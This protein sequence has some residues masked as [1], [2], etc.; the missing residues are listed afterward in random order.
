MPR[1]T[2][3]KTTL[4]GSYPATLPLVADSADLNLQASTGSAGSNGNQIA[5]SAAKLLVLIQ[6]SHATNAGTVTITSNKDQYNRSGDIS[7]YS[8]AAGDIAPFY[9]ERAGWIQSD[10]Y[11]YLECSAATMKIAAIDLP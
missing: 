6:N 9:L 10:G 8:L 3:A 2:I 7:A 11:L 5:F 1:S 4:V